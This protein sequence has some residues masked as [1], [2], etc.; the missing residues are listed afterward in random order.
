M[1][2]CVKVP[3]GVGGQH[4]NATLP[5]KKKNPVCSTVSPRKGALSGA[6]AGCECSL[7]ALLTAPDFLPPLVLFPLSFLSFFLFF[8]LVC[9][10]VGYVTRDRP[11]PPRREAQIGGG[12]RGGA[13]RGRK[14]EG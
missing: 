5:I 8:S 3:V 9:Q 1:Y 4:L 7:A 10:R 12:R 14:V 2:V 6:L 11:T 13:G